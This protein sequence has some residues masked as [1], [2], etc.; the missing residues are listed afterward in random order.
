[1]PVPLPATAGG[2]PV[3]SVGLLPAAFMNSDIATQIVR[4]YTTRGLT[5]HDGAGSAW[6]TSG[7]IAWSSGS[8]QRPRK[9]RDLDQGGRLCRWPGRVAGRGDNERWQ[10]GRQGSDD[11][12]DW[13]GLNRGIDHYRLSAVVVTVRLGITDG[14]PGGLAGWQAGRLAGWQGSTVERDSKDG[15]RHG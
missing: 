4:D 3:A 8:N 15:C 14:R 13:D 6:G 12:V 7:R 11:G 5:A 1:M 2:P 9:R 10:I